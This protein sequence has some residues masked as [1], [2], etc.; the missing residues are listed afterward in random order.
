MH[1][2]LEIG[3]DGLARCRWGIG[4]DAL[5]RRYHDEEWGRPVADVVRLFEKIA[6]EGFQSGLSWL[7]ILRKREGFRRAFAGFEPA[8]VAGF[9]P[10]DVE[11]LLGDAGIVRNRAKI[12]AVIANAGR[13]LD[14]AADGGLAAFAWRH[15]GQPA[16]LSRELKK[17]GWRFVGPTTIESFM[18]AV[19]M[20][21]DHAEGCFAR[22]ICER[23]REAFEVP[24]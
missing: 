22:E 17:R 5:F 12:E 8:A 13:C 23:E 15:A 2:S 3:S 20:V 10:A 9:G 19:G 18:Q 6:L 14:M 16:L 21:N 7:L 11:R 24:A 4:E 1:E